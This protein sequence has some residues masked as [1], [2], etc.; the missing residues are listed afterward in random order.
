MPNLNTSVRI[1]A[2]Q[3]YSGVDSAS[4]QTAA[5]AYAGPDYNRNVPDGS[6]SG[7]ANKRIVRQGTL[8]TGNNLDLDLAGSL[9]DEFGQ[10]CVFTAIMGIVLEAV[11]GNTGNLTLGGATNAFA[12]FLGANTHTL[13]LQPKG[14]LSFIA[15][16]AGYAVTAG[17][18]DI[19]RVG[20]ASGA[21]QGYKLTVFGR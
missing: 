20:N 9:T 8:T 6:S 1:A 11:D 7:Q 19:L 5:S 12:S 13:V 18:G 15:G 4:G 21:T 3:Q 16:D 10:A 14:C 2:V 17:T